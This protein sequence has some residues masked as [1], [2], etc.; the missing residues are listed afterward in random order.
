M[1]MLASTVELLVGLFLDAV[2]LLIAF[3]IVGSI[4]AALRAV[5]GPSTHKETSRN[6]DIR[7]NRV[8]NNL[9]SPQKEEAPN[10]CRY[11]SA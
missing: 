4:A 5:G 1:R 8:A 9:I 7:F 10:S 11:L 3:C 6:T 2:I